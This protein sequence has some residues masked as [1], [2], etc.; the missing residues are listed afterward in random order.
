MVDKVPYK[1]PEV[2]IDKPKQTRNTLGDGVT[3]RTNDGNDKE[4]RVIIPRTTPVPPVT[5]T[6]DKDKPP[7]IPIVTPTPK[8][9]GGETRQGGREV[10]DIPSPK[11][12]PAPQ[13]K[14]EP[15]QGKGEVNQGGS[16]VPDTVTKTTPKVEPTPEPKPEPIPDKGVVEQRGN[17]VPDVKPQAVSPTDLPS[18]TVPDNGTTMQ[19][20]ASFG[21]ATTVTGA[22]NADVDPSVPTAS[23]IEKQTLGE[24]LNGIPNV[25]QLGSSFDPNK[26]LNSLTT[27]ELETLMA[28]AEKTIEGNAGFFEAMF[29]TLT[30]TNEKFFFDRKGYDASANAGI[31]ENEYN[32]LKDLIAERK[33]YE[34][35]M[36]SND[37]NHENSYGGTTNDR[38]GSPSGSSSSGS[39]GG[40]GNADGPDNGAT[41]Q[42]GSSFNP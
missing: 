6:N 9:D 37:N 36:N 38:G 39:V 11:T 1:V 35:Q 41:N 27:R 5:P 34:R 15:V 29:D 16:V 3:V 12:E 28:S 2:E 19:G 10:P 32:A 8:N 23:T 4:P 33:E 30:G 22:S 26:S 17:V 42:G 14:P 20:G 24:F 40:S 21:G 31:S 13:P 7:I 18:P 25:E